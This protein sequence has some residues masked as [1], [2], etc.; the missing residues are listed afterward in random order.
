MTLVAATAAGADSIDDAERLRHAGMS[1]IFS[2]MRAPSTVGH[3]LRSYT[4]GHVQQL[5]TSRQVLGAL[6]GQAPLFKEAGHLAFVDIDP[7]Y[8][9]VYGRPKQGAQIGE[10]AEI[11]SSTF[12]TGRRK[13]QQVTAR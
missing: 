7:T 10:V 8:Q 2:D 4:R 5:H 13:D 6:A 3:F 11:P 12:F 1:H 9:R